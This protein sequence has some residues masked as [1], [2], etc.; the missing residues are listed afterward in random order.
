MGRTVVRV[1]ANFVILTGIFLLGKVLFN[2]ADGVLVQHYF[3]PSQGGRLENIYA[4]GLGLPVP[5]HVISVGLVLQLRWL[6][7]PWAKGARWAVVV[8]GCW[9]ALALGIR[10]LAL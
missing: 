1:T 3:G 2:S 10:W 4:L 5:L 9:L 7:T 8:S 6:S